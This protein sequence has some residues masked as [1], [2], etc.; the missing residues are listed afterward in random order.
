MKSSHVTKL[1]RKA[2]CVWLM[3]QFRC[4]KDGSLTNVGQNLL[5]GWSPVAQSKCEIEF[6][7][8]SDTQERNNGDEGEV[9]VDDDDNDDEK[10]G[11][12]A[13]DDDND[14]NFNDGMMVVII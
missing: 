11:D 1:L 10:D 5:V 4:K 7:A 9:E 12:E 2:R 14:D 6:E 8:I 13:D 3:V